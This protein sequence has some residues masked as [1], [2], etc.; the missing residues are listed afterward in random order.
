MLLDKY[1][2][3]QFFFDTP[4]YKV[5]MYVIVLCCGP[6]SVWLCSVV[7]GQGCIELFSWLKGYKA[8]PFMFVCIN[9][10]V[11]NVEVV[12]IAWWIFVSKIERVGPLQLYAL[13]LLVCRLCALCAPSVQRC[14]AMFCAPAHTEAVLCMQCCLCL[15]V[16]ESVCTISVLCTLDSCSVP[17]VSRKCAILCAPTMLCALPRCSWAPG[18][19][20]SRLY[21]CCSSLVGAH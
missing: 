6:V 13:S 3:I 1:S 15:N 5:L 14:V 9:L 16:C 11:K 4:P 7:Q 17:C 19:R 21:S 10:G 18:T 20:R 2:V 12:H 8:L